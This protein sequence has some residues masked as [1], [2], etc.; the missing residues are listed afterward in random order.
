MSSDDAFTLDKINENYPFISNSDANYIYNELGKP[1]KKNNNSDSCYPESKVEGDHNPEIEKILKDYYS[2]LYKITSAAE[3]HT[4]DYY[5]QDKFDE[6]KKMGVIYLKYWLY[7]KILKTYTGDS[8]IE[9]IFQGLKNYI[10]PKIEKKY[11]N[12]CK[13][14]ELTLSEIK[15]MKKLYALYTIFYGNTNNPGSCI[16]DQCKYMDYFGEGLDEFISSINKCS[17]EESTG[18]Y[19]KEFEEFLNIC[20]DEKLNAG[21]TVHEESTKGKADGDKK[22]LLFSEKYNDQTLYIYLRNKEMLNFL[23]T[24]NFLS[25]KSTTIAATSVVGSAVGLSSI[26]YYFYKVILNDIFKFKYCT[27]KNIE[28]ARKILL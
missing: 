3:G 21:I 23:K 24:S 5:D 13:I 2:S 20:K 16:G 22:Y 17:S 27:L 7:D 1:C 9:K 19:C 10:E 12:Y 28:Y 26:F 8:N 18:N 6:I 15:S 14:N 4:N 11:S 25:N